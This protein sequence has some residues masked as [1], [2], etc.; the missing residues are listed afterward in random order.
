[1]NAA[2]TLTT[3]IGWVIVASLVV[4][5]I[6]NASKFAVVIGSASSALISESA[7]LTGSGYGQAGYGQNTYS[8]QKA[9]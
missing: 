5:V 1:M 8:Y 2:S 4:L 7:L 6:M 3:W 9:A